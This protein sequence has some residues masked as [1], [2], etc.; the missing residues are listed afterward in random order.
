MLL[1]IGSPGQGAGSIRQ[2]ATPIP[3][4]A[5]LL[6][7]PRDRK[8]PGV[9]NEPAESD[10][11]ELHRLRLVNR[12]DGPIQVSTDGGKSWQLLGRVMVPAIAVIQGYL[13]A[14]YA[15]QGTVAATA[16]HGLRIRTG[17]DERAFTAPAVLSLEPAEYLSRAT[18]GKVNK[19]YGG[20][21]AGAAGIFTDIPAGTSLFRDLAPFV[22]NPVYLESP[23]GRLDPLPPDFRPGAW[24]EILVI[25]VRAPKNSLVEV[26]I[27]NRAGGKVEAKFADGTTRQITQVVQ[28][29]RGVGRFDGTAYTGLGRLNTAHTGVITV[30]TAMINGA[31]PEGEGKERRGGFQIS[32]VWHNGRVEE[33]GAPVVMTL[34]VP[35]PRRRDLEGTA[36]LFKDAVGLDPVTSTEVGIV[37]CSIDDGPWEQM[38]YIVGSR[39]TALTG[40]GLTRV[41]RE[42]GFSRTAKKGIT[43][44][45]IRLPERKPER[46]QQLA[47]AAVEAYRNIRLK[48]AR[49]GR[50]PIV[51][52]VLT[53]NANP[54]QNARVAFVR[55]LVEGSPRGFTNVAPFT[56]T[57]D[58]TRVP[59]GEY[60]IEA[61]ALDAGGGILATNRRRVF[62]LNH[63]A[64]V[65]AS[66]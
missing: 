44:F 64:A 12:K 57:W 58:T 26:V 51:Q 21:R 22:G 25:V 34:G 61:H 7:V 10:Y 39:P 3:A 46:Y 6:P 11:I 23:T 32:P 38:P 4:D 52:G 47:M 62:V 54:T 42:Q 13:A 45:R 29:V 16:V 24:G 18:G 60:L 43:A 41:W 50:V 49:A 40:P 37:D 27:E 8:A 48:A 1:C 28:P 66:K 36:P 2:E 65:S 30:S 5:P 59:D 15:P 35:G 9:S 63:P 56:L 14:N 33:A 20:H 55:L 53:V 19:G 31:Q 17:G